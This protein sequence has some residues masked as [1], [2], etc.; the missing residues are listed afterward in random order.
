MQ[1]PTCMMMS[2][3]RA[4]V[5]LQWHAIKNIWGFCSPPD[6]NTV[7][8]CNQQQLLPL[9]LHA[10]SLFPLFLHALTISECSIT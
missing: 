10:L 4:G 1:W 2:H 7:I 6:I 5:K 9:F 3:T 8:A